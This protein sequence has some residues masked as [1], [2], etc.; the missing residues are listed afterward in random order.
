VSAALAAKDAT[1]LIVDD[2]EVNIALL[3]DILSQAGYTSI[4]GTTD[5]YSVPSLLQEIN[6]DLL[7]LDLA[8]PGQDGFGVLDELR[9]LLPERGYFPI[10]VLTADIT[11]QAKERALRGGAKDFLTKPFDVTEILLRI[12]NLIETRLLHRRL[13]EHAELLDEKVRART[14]ELE[15]EVNERKQAELALRESELRYRQLVEGTS[16]FAGT[17]SEDGRFL[18]LNRAFLEAL[19]YEA[20]ELINVP[21]TEIMTPEARAIFEQRFAQVLAARASRDIRTTMKAK[22]GRT[23]SMEGSVAVGSTRSGAPCAHGVFRDVTARLK[24]ERA[25]REKELAEASSSAKSQML[26]NMSHELRTPLN[27]IIGFGRVLAAGSYGALNE[28]QS[29]YVGHIV[30]AGEHMLGLVNGLLDLRKIEENKTTME[31]VPV[32]LHA[33][34]ADAEV[35]VA[36]LFQERGHKLTSRSAGAPAVI[37]D[38]SSLVQVLVNLLS[39]AAK[40]TPPSGDIEIR[41]SAAAGAVTVEVEDN[42]VGIK[43]EDRERIFD[44]FVQVGERRAQPMKGYG[45]GLALTRKLVEAMN[46]KIGVRSAPSSGSVF[47]ITLPAAERGAEGI[48]G[49]L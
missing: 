27:S 39:N 25:Q 1:I 34:V 12:G 46:G 10:L 47:W 8:M 21:I 14:R 42:G 18:F 49:K 48:E 44:Y 31:L 43:P 16:D 11:P 28:R 19:G 40:Y 6:P 23:F 37:A 9:P 26:A 36:A 32:P 22:D 7:L 38:H 33:A 13:K 24:A 29:G 15:E 30:R 20:A 5:P 3:E 2:Q 17:L 4:R 41:V 45:I 35:M